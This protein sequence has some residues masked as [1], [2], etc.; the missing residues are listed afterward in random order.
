MNIVQIDIINPK[1]TKLLQSMVDLELICIKSNN[2]SEIIEMARTIRK[3]VK[4]KTPTLAEITKEVEI[5]RAK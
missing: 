2:N 4:L 3:K 5:V 1:A